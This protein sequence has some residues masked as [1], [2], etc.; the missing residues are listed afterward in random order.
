M[1]DPNA[2]IAARKTMREAFEADPE[3]GGFYDSYVANVAMVLHDMQP[4]GGF[5]D[6][7]DY[8]VRNAVARRVLEKIFGQ[9]KY[10]WTC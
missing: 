1:S 5:M 4:E 8:E 7:K 9:T 10:D 3:P 2:I 6:F